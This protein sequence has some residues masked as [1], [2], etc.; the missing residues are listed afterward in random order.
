MPPFVKNRAATAI[1][2][3][4]LRIASRPPDAMAATILVSWLELARRPSRT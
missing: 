2:A 4:L 1:R 3:R